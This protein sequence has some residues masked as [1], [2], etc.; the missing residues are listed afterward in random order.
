MKCGIVSCY[1]VEMFLDALLYL[2]SFDTCSKWTHKTF[3]GLKEHDWAVW[4]IRSDSEDSEL[5]ESGRVYPQ[6]KFERQKV[7]G[8]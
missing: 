8:Q 3:Y 4:V 7:R 2:Q 6:I 1:N 5:E